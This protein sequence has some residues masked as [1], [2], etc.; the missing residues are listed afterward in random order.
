MFF[1]NLTMSFAWPFLIMLTLLVER[2]FIK[3]CTESGTRHAV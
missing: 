2:V 1:K 3:N